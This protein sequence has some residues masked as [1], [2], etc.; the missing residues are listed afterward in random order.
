MFNCPQAPKHWQRGLLIRLEVWLHLLVF[1]VQAFT[2]YIIY[3]E[4][5]HEGLC[6]GKSY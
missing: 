1:K 6:S 4:K 2:L 3:V 5:N